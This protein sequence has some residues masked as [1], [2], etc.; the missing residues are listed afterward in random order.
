[1][2]HLAKLVAEDGVRALDAKRERMS[3]EPVKG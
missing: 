1:M 2:G 3:G